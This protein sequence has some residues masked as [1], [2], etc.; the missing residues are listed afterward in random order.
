MTRAAQTVPP[1]AL[2][3]AFQLERRR[4][5][6]LIGGG[7]K[8]TLLFRLAAALVARGRTVLTTTST[9][10]LPPG[11]ELSPRT[12]VEAEVARLVAALRA[13]PT[14]TPPRHTTVARA[15]TPD[16]AKLL[17]FAP[18]ELDALHDAQVADALLVEADGSAGRPLKA[19]AAH[20]PVLSARADLVVLVVGGDVFGRPFGPETVH[21]PELFRRRVPIAD[22]AAITPDHVRAALVGSGGYLAAVPPG[23]AALLYVSR[24]PLGPGAAEQARARASAEALAG[25]TGISRVVLADLAGGD[26]A[27][28]ESLVIVDR[29]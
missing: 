12:L 27:G 15:V 5:V 8:T 6:F 17:G 26:G 19:H 3:D 16:G 23:C 4:Y 10:I 22:G 20:E 24:F 14:P 28:A 2:F 13:A 9:R 21:R 7:G 1:H 29:P 18:A 25:G 11:P